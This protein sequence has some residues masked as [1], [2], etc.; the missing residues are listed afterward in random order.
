MG[1]CTSQTNNIGAN[2]LSVSILSRKEKCDRH[3]Q[4][5]LPTY[6][7]VECV[8]MTMHVEKFISDGNAV[9]SYHTHQ[10]TH[11]YVRTVHTHELP[12]NLHILLLAFSEV[13]IK[14]F[15]GVA[16]GKV[17]SYKHNKNNNKNYYSNNINDETA[18]L[19]FW[20]SRR[21]TFPSKAIL[22]RKHAIHTTN[23]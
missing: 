5:I 7:W 14:N 19:P 2:L 20:L 17:C 11:I 9:G 6:A 23:I 4:H 1:V 18:K 22:Q 16:T 15:K 3:T 12:C 10:R 21:R 8:F 13:C